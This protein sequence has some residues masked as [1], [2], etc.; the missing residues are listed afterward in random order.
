M[1]DREKY[2]RESCRPEVHYTAESHIINDPNG[3]FYYDGEY[4]LMHQYNIHNHIH[5]GHAVS[6]D[7]V[8]WKHLPTALAPDRIGQ[9]WSGS[10]VVDR[11]NTSGLQCG[12]EQVIAALFTYNEHID[13]QQ[14]QGLAYSNDRGRT[15]KK[16]E[17]NPVLTSG[18]KPDFRDPKVF[19]FEEENCWI[20][21]LACGDHVEFYRSDN[22]I[23]WEFSGEFGA[24]S[25]S[26]EGVW[27]CPDL[28]RLPVEDCP[29]ESRWVLLVS[30]NRG[31]PAGGTGMQYFTGTFDGK[32]FENDNPDDQVFWLDY[33]KDF[34]AG[35]TWNDIPDNDGRR[36][37]IGWADNWVYRDHLPTS[38]FKGQFSSVRE[39]RLIKRQ[40]DI[41][42]AQRPVRELE[43]LRDG[44]EEF[45]CKRENGKD[46]WQVPVESGAF[47]VVCDVELEKDDAVLDFILDGQRGEFIRI[48][49]DAAGEYLEFD[50]SHY[51]S[52]DIDQFAGIFRAPLKSRGNRLTFHILVDVSQIEIFADEG[53][54]VMTDLYFGNRFERIRMETGISEVKIRRCCFYKLASVW[55]D[56]RDRFSGLDEV[57]SG[58]WAQTIEGLEGDC[59][60]EGML[61][62]SRNYEDF[63]MEGKMKIR[64]FREKK[65]SG[66][67]FGITGKEK[68]HQLLFDAGEHEIRLMRAGRLL[69]KTG[70][71]INP[72]RTY[73]IQLQ[74]RQRKLE[75]SCDGMIVLK[76]E[77]DT[78]IGG[79]AGAC[80][81]NTNAVFHDIRI[82][83]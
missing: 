27:E 54:V 46:R 76:T 41:R 5:W 30:V 64:T 69:C 9:I 58:K 36:L 77:L 40:D 74:V 17:H 80:V 28:F 68:G 22:L 26:H 67:I 51:G 82:R 48:T 70:F 73:N 71:M 24:K 10:A 72:D 62:C 34:Y 49:Y 19:W 18:G 52:Y 20:M 43:C 37:L 11:D 59:A 63:I 13:S 35:V 2:F 83:G 44:A 75:V 55:S 45:I 14:I 53:S 1:A 6:D 21:V 65:I 66:F 81:C 78:Y 7:L 31:A 42:I 16:Y 61:V 47:E 15:W 56:K 60:T 38:P 3:L 33:G 39:L 50:R 79:K 23:D 32:T 25:G 57:V 29:G 8:H 12:R 4:H